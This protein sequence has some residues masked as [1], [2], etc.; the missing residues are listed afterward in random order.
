VANAAGIIPGHHSAGGAH[1][2]EMFKQGFKFCYVCNDGR[3]LAAAAAEA[4]KATK[5]AM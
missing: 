2:A 5:D 4:L 1:T 3:L